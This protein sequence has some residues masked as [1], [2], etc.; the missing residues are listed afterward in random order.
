MAIPTASSAL[1]FVGRQAT[2]TR[3]RRP[4]PGKVVRQ[5]AT[6][7]LHSIYPTG[8]GPISRLRGRPRLRRRLRRGESRYGAAKARPRTTPR[9]PMNTIRCGVDLRGP[10]HHRGQRMSSP[11]MKRISR[12][13]GRCSG[14]LR[15]WRSEVAGVTFAFPPSCPSRVAGGIDVQRIARVAPMQRLSRIVLYRCTSLSEPNSS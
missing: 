15:R 8:C 9:L 1:P 4:H 5:T 7:L 14:L 2:P 10:L 6:P 13:L 11:I 3:G 12:T